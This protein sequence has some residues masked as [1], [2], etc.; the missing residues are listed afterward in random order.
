MKKSEVLAGIR[1]VAAEFLESPVQIEPNAKI[2]DDLRLDSLDL[3]TLVV[4]LENKFRICI[5][6]ADA[7]ELRTISDLADYIAERTRDAHLDG[8]STG[9]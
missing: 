6:D 2:L 4:E 7:A 9:G 3:L 5:D 1:A 8:G